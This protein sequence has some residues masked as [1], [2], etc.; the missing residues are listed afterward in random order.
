MKT[1]SKARSRVR[2]YQGLLLGIFVLVLALGGVAAACGPPTAKASGDA[3][4]LTAVDVTL[5]GTTG[6]P[7]CTRALQTATSTSSRQT[8]TRTR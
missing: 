5:T 7:T 6:P 8:P 1:P 2:G 4:A 3:H